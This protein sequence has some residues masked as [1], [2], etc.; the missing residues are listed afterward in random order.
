[1]YQF[2]LLSDLA[3]AQGVKTIGS[4]CHEALIK[5]LKEKRQ[6][7]GIRQAEVAKKMKKQQ[8]W[9]S[10]IEKGDRRLDVCQFLQLADLIDFDP[11]EALRAVDQA[12]NKNKR[13]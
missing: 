9:M 13:K 1:M 3:Y 8:N 12:R 6:A 11:I 7:R 5:L 4:P 2:G 10:R